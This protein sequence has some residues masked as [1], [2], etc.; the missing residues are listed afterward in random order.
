MGREIP[1]KEAAW[2]GANWCRNDPLAPF[3]FARLFAVGQT[4]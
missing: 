3:I 1:K 2:L 4:G